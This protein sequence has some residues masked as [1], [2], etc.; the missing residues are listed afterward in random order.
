MCLGAF[1]HVLEL[2]DCNIVSRGCKFGWWC[3][4]LESCTAAFKKLRKSPFHY[5]L[6]S[7]WPWRQIQSH[8]A[9]VQTCVFLKHTPQHVR[10]NVMREF[11]KTRKEFHG[12]GRGNIRND[13]QSSGYFLE[14]EFAAPGQLYVSFS[15]KDFTE[16]LAL[17]FLR[18][19]LK[20]SS[21]AWSVFWHCTK[22]A[23]S[24]Q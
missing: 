18:V 24:H 16:M 5:F 20:D 2:K 7:I 14:K 3:L 21:E 17:H 15:C 9:W 19:I 1:T 13:L 10:N 11:A 4:A 12:L 23:F 6:Y 22:A 8:D